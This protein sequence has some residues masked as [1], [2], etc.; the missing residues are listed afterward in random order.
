MRGGRSKG[1][2]VKSGPSD[3]PS[4]YWLDAGFLLMRKQ[5]EIRKS[6]RTTRKFRKHF[7]ISND[8]VLRFIGWRRIWWQRSLDGHDDAPSM[9]VKSKSFVQLPGR[10]VNPFVKVTLFECAFDNLE[11]S[12][13]TKRQHSRLLTSSY[14]RLRNNLPK[15]RWR[16]TSLQRET[17]TRRRRGTPFISESLSVIS[18]KQLRQHSFRS[19]VARN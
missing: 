13:E 2:S 8:G 1:S 3:T 18:N 10:L 14:I 15:R 6:W 7:G 16:K 12:H 5:I 11:I 9:F 4:A 17:M 19:T